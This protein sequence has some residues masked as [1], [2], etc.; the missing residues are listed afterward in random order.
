MSLRGKGR[1]RPVGSG[2]TRTVTIPMEVVT[3]SQWP[4]EDGEIVDIH[5]T[6][7]P[8]NEEDRIL[9]IRKKKKR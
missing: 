7:D 3:D 5:L 1:V 8:V 9:I 4:F 2:R 6:P